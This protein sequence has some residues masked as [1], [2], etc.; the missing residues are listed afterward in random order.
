MATRLKA[1][2]PPTAEP[3]DGTR[4]KE[5]IAVGAVPADY[6]E[7]NRVAWER[8]ALSYTAT[9]RKAWTE[10]ELRWGIW[11]IPESELGLLSPFP[12]GSDVIEL[13]CGTASISA[14][15]A[16]AGLRPVAVDV[17][18]AQLNVATR[19]QDE[20]GPTFPLIHANAEDVPYDSENFDLVISEYGASLWCEPHRWLTEASRLLR[21]RGSLIIVTN[22]PLLMACTPDDGARAGD[23]LLHDHFASPV[24]EYPDDGVVEFHLT[25]GNWIE[26]LTVYGFVVERLVELRPPHGAQPRFDF[27]SLEWARRWPSEEIWVARKAR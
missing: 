10:S 18:R 4:P 26:L 21:P 9:A 24:R 6:V 27:V 8:W 14:W 5:I 15:A 2:P 12:E 11:R 7:R 22:S 20:L 16:R 1:T 13:G 25:H 3:D 19:L 17:S 23:R